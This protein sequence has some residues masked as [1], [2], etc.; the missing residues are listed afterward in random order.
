MSR[1]FPREGDLD[2]RAYLPYLHKL[3]KRKYCDLIFYFIR[4]PGCLWSLK[5]DSRVGCGS[6]PRRL[7]VGESLESLCVLDKTILLIILL[8]KTI[9]K[10]W[11]PRV[12]KCSSTYTKLHHH[13]LR[14]CLVVDGNL[15]VFPK[16]KAIRSAVKL[17]CDS[18]MYFPGCLLRNMFKFK[19]RERAR[20]ATAP[21]ASCLPTATAIISI[22]V[23][24]AWECNYVVIF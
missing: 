11:A 19:R 5:C 9:M 17:G 21:I 10:Q 6:L 1:D 14:S 3:N 23:M 7:A 4:K 13:D 20:R 18:L 16:T 2:F 15:V 12:A 24:D 8:W 22:I